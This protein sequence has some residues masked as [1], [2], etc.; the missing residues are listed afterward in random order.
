MKMTII[1]DPYINRIRN[2]YYGF[3]IDNENKEHRFKE[4]SN[5]WMISV[6]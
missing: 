6:F 5:Y 2:N 3:S 1:F 4:Y